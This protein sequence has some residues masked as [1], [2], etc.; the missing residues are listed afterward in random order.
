[1]H[2]WNPPVIAKLRGYKRYMWLRMADSIAVRK[3][4]ITIMVSREGFVGFT[5]RYPSQIEKIIHI[6]TFLDDRFVVV[7]NTQDT[8]DKVVPDGDPILLCVS[9]LVPEKQVKKAIEVLSVVKKTLVGARLYVVGDGAERK[10]LEYVSEQ[11]GV[12]EAV[13]F[14]G[15]IPHDRIASYFSAADFFLMPSIWEGRSIAL[16]EALAHG[17][18]AVLTNIA[19]HAVLVGNGGHGCVIDGFEFTRKAAEW[20]VDRY[21]QIRG[22]EVPRKQPRT[23][24]LASA[25]VPQVCTILHEAARG[26]RVTSGARS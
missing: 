11:L 16:L 18:P 1:M 15:A 20:I 19:D 24:Y 12:R 9:R 5:R 3:A 23:D 8:E 13:R 17:V 7:R 25:L 21:A 4:T 10:A 2:G 6:P 14:E 26:H 22:G